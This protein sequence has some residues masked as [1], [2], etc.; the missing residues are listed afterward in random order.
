[1]NMVKSFP[2]PNPTRPNGTTPAPYQAPGLGEKTIEDVRARRALLYARGMTHPPQ[3]GQPQPGPPP[4]TTTTTTIPAPSPEYPR[5]PLPG[6]F[7]GS[8]SFTPPA[9]VTGGMLGV[10]DKIGP[11]RT[12]IFPANASAPSRV[13]G[14]PRGSVRAQL[15]RGPRPGRSTAFHD[16]TGSSV[17]SESGHYARV[18]GFTS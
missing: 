17:G 7:I 3:P 5:G 2:M 15:S 11:Q 8:R 14:V 13:L 18:K 1:M 6:I 16:Y 9:G 12:P 10:G 4:G